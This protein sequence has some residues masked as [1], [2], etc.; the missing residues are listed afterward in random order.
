[1]GRYIIG[2]TGASGSIYGIR[3]IEE[4]I[5]HDHEVFL[6][7][8]DAGKLVIQHEIGWELTGDSS[9]VESNLKKYLQAKI[10]TDKLRYFDI[11]HVGALIA[12]GSF[13][14]NGMII[15]PCTMSAVSAIALG[16]SSDLLERAADV[17]LKEKRQLI[18]VPREAPLSQ[19]HL[20]NLLIL[21][22]MGVHIMPPVTAFYFKPHTID[23]L[24]DYTVGRILDLLDIDHQLLDR[25]QG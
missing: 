6:T 23:D 13:K 22:Q 15:V 4:L 9:K 11:N 24:V 16:A 8:T 10:S 2:I 18:I 7:I 25:W 19:V 1:M 12:S 21:A 14:T 17:V 5:K 3:L 20:R